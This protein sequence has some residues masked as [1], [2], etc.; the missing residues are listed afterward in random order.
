MSRALAGTHH[1]VQTHDHRKSSGVFSTHVRVIFRYIRVVPEY[2]RVVSMYDRVVPMHAR[3][4]LSETSLGKLVGKLPVGDRQVLVRTNEPEAKSTR[5][6]PATRRRRGYSC[7]QATRAKK[8]ARSNQAATTRRTNSGNYP[9]TENYSCE[10]TPT[11]G[12]APDSDYHDR[13]ARRPTPSTLTDGVASDS[14]TTAG[15]TP[16]STSL[17]DGRRRTNFHH[18]AAPRPAP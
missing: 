13:A 10:R 1:R 3:E 18:A 17:H 11:G 16:C 15:G 6:Q 9:G 14:S 2:F 12:A 8:A 4:S 5:Q 7:Q